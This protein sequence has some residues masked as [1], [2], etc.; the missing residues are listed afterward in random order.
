MKGMGLDRSTAFALI[1]LLAGIVI[2]VLIIIP[3]IPPLYGADLDSDGVSDNFQRINERQDHRLDEDGEWVTERVGYTSSFDVPLLAFTLIGLNLAVPILVF[4]SLWSKGRRSTAEDEGAERAGMHDGIRRIATFLE[5]NPSLISALK[6]AHASMP[7]PGRR[8]LGRLLWAIRSKGSDFREEYRNFRAEWMDRDPLVGKAL[9]DLE[10]AERE[11]TS[12]EVSLSARRAMDELTEGTRREMSK[13]VQSLQGPTTALFAIGVLLPVLLATMIPISGIGGSSVFMI[14]FLLWVAIPAGIVLMGRRI[15]SR[16]PSF[17][18]DP[19]DNEAE[20]K[21][22]FPRMAIAGYVL[23]TLFVIFFALYRYDIG[24]PSLS[25]TGLDSGETA[26]F[27]LLWGLSILAA[28]ATMHYTFGNAERA[29]HLADVDRQIPD[30]LRSLGSGISDGLSFEG[31]SK[32][33]VKPGILEPYRSYLVPSPGMDP[34]K[35][36]I[37]A[38][39]ENAYRAAMHFARSGADSGGRAIRALGGHMRSLL[40]L[41]DEMIQRID[42]SIGQMNITASVFAPIMIGASVGIFR[43]LDPGALSSDISVLGGGE[44]PMGSSTFVLISGVYLILL[45]GASSVT[46]ARLRSGRKNGGWEKVPSSMIRST[47]SFT[48]G[49]VLAIAVVG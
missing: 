1:A 17:R 7:D 2:S 41:E 38:S 24:M 49:A 31:A 22:G 16:R 43:L 15:V 6:Y 11:P 19:A 20:K 18:I 28:S 48:A 45:S 27:T 32:R 44:D 26:M 46:I 30:L 36:R 14:A 12:L 10:S 25:W 13:Y 8:S 3:G 39:L 40:S 29:L 42:S 35:G 21:K 9:T 34:D 23:G 47:L 4:Y 33:A 37:P 5:V